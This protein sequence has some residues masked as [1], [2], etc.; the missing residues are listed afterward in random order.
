MKIDGIKNKI[1]FEKIATR[2]LASLRRRLRAVPFLIAERGFLSPQR[3]LLVRFGL[4]LPR[5]AMR[6]YRMFLAM[7]ALIFLLLGTLQLIEHSRTLK[8]QVLGEATTAFD[9]L[10]SGKERLLSEDFEN[11]SADLRSATER[12]AA[13]REKNLLK[14]TPLSGELDTILKLGEHSARALDHL[15]LGIGEFENMRLSWDIETNSSDQGLYLHLKNSRENMLI[16]LGELYKAAELS[17]QVNAALLSQE[18]SMVFDKAAEELAAAQSAIEA[19]LNLE[20]FVLNFIAGEHKTY[21]L[22]FQNNNEAR[23]TGGFIGTYGLVEFDNGRVKLGR[24][25]SIYNL[26]GQLK[27]KIAAPGPLQRQVSA[28]WGIRDSNWF[29]DFG[30]SSR[31]ILEFFEKETGILPDGVISFTPDVFEKL[32]T[33][34]GPI[35]MPSYGLTL[36]AE[37]FRSFAQ[38]K[39]SVD[40][41]RVENE[42][43]KF[44]ADFAPLFLEYLSSLDRAQWLEFVRLF[45]QFSARK[46]ILIYALDDRI[47]GGIRSNGLAGE[48]LQTEGDYLMI[49]HSNVG[50]GKTDLG[51]AQAVEK[52]VSVDRAGA[53][54]V[55]LKI[56][57]THQSFNEK[58]LPQNL[59]F[60]RILAPRGSALS[61]ASGFEATE[62]QPSERADAVT[63]ADLAAWDAHISKSEQGIFVGEEAGYTEFSGWLA[64]LPGETKTL[65]IVYRLPFAVEERYTQLLQKQP[66]QRPFD[67][68][69]VVDWPRQTVY[70]FPDNFTVTVDTDKFFGLVGE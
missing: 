1:N 33:L 18:A 23:A 9:E 10:N 26:D 21:L 58:N 31:K 70:S 7:A 24:I 53:A 3:R 67:F 11:A 28:Y 17:A 48:I 6:S 43:K 50:G 34:T 12:F 66:G 30:Q 29:A 63:D 20:E 15:T 62:F 60:V 16:S 42:P 37:N 61:S 5:G 54:E 64:L 38:Y 56:V 2:K 41:D 35:P 27:E 4:V 39:T 55:K 49:I 14:N 22:I 59:D 47:Q 19:V 8:Q 25:E 45:S 44:L 40:Y 32:L 65:E 52:R 69:L 68:S 57:R 36:T 51:I 13:L 46:Q